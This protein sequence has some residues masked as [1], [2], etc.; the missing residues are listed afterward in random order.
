[1]LCFALRS[2]YPCPMPSWRTTASH[3]S[4]TAY[5]IQF[6]ATL[7]IRRP[8]SPTAFA[9]WSHS[10][11]WWKGTPH[12]RNWCLLPFKCSYYIE[13]SRNYNLII[14]QSSDLLV[15]ILSTNVDYHYPRVVRHNSKI[16]NIT[17]F[18]PLTYRNKI[19]IIKL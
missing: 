2:C 18:E 11:P 1:M 4:T 15:C 10:M 19:Q 7:H 3:L 12:K 17:M 5:S 13:A 9:T 14:V 16:C 6:A 8:Y